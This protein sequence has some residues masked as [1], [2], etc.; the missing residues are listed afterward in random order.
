MHT[1]QAKNWRVA[2]EIASIVTLRC[3]GKYDGLMRKRKLKQ[4]TPRRRVG[5]GD[6]LTAREIEIARLLSLGCSV[7][8]V[9]AILG[10]AYPCSLFAILGVV[11][12]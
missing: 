7:G 12:G 9:G 8:E 5:P 2:A 10:I 1:A 4:A 11:F 6:P 3:S